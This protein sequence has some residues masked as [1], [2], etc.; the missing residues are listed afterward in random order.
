MESHLTEES[1]WASGM[2]GRL[3]LLQASC[4]DEPAETLQECLSEEIGRALKEI[5]LSKKRIYLETLAEKFPTWQVAALP[6]AAVQNKAEIV[7]DTPELRLASLVQIVPQLSP[8]QK[9]EF[10][11]KLQR[12]GLAEEKEGAGLVITAE[13]QKIFGL[14]ADQKL[15]AERAVKLLATLAELVLALDQLVWNLWKQLAPKAAI[16]R[17]PGPANDFRDNARR[18]LIGDVEVSTTQL[19]QLLDQSR[20]LIAGLLMAIGGVGR[21]YAK[22]HQERLSPDIIKDLAELEKGGWG[23]NLEQKCWRK[24]VELANEHASEPAI[25]KEIQDT[26]ARYA[27]EVMRG[28]FSN[29]AN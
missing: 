28:R 14:A 3:R 23:T 16:R 18:Y 7:E 12:A 20:K 8:E 9:A 29:P 15:S 21:S 1:L 26:I 6:G 5:P 17:P 4:A 11:R 25:E 10:A 19:T 2:A 22:K 27:E 24:Y 13:L